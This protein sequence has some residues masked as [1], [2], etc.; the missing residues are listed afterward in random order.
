M[1]ELNYQAKKKLYDSKNLFDTMYVDFNLTDTVYDEFPIYLLDK[2]E[3][4]AETHE[5]VL[6][7]SFQSKLQRRLNKLHVEESYTEEHSSWSAFYALKEVIDQVSAIVP[8]EYTPY[9]RGQAGNWE[10]QPTIFRSGVSGYSDEFRENYEH[11]YKDIAQKYPEDVA[12]FLP[13]DKEHLDDRAA[14]LA[15]LQHY[16]LGT[17]LVDISENPFVSLLFMVDGYKGQ[18]NEPQLDIFFVKNDGNNTLFQQVMKKVQNRRIAAQKGAFLNFDKWDVN[19]DHNNK[20]PRICLRLKY[21]AHNLNNN[22]DDDLPD[23]QDPFDSQIQNHNKNKALETAVNDIKEK[24]ESYHYRTEDLFPDFYMY[25]G[26]VKH[27]YS[28]TKDFSKNSRWYQL[29]D[30]K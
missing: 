26:I 29:N 16:G 4:D 22:E 18:G 23:G 7:E 14:N 1:T 17:P 24:L 28:G 27:R 10:I 5:N 11:I 20:I 13:D 3:V 2:I 19:T 30:D 21:K 12:Y 9:Y 25:L 15:E 6:L 8:N